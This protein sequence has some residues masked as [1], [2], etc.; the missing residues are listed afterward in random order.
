M[1]EIFIIPDFIKEYIAKCTQESD[2]RLNG[3]RLA[4]YI[5]PEIQ[6]WQ[7]NNE[8][9]PFKVVKQMLISGNYKHPKCETCGKIFPID[10]YGKRFCN[11]SCEMKCKEINEYVSK[12]S[13]SEKAKEKRKQTN[14][15]KYGVEN[16][17]ALKENREGAMLKKYGVTHALKMESSKNKAKKTNLERYGCENPH[18]NKDIIE[19]AE[20]TNIEKYGCKNVFQNEEIK[21]KIKEKNIEKYGA[22][23]FTQT[24]EYKEKCKITFNERYGVDNPN[25]IAEIKEKGTKTLIKKNRMKKYE[26]IKKIL[27]LKNIL[28]DM[29]KTEYINSDTIKYR[30]LNCNLEFHSEYTDPYKINCS[31]CFIRYG[32]SISE[33]EILD[34]VKT[35]YNN[36]IEE[37][38]RKIISPFELDIYIPEK[39]LAIEFNG[40]YWHSE[41]II[42]DKKYHQTKTLKCKEQGIRLIHIFE[43]EWHNK[44]DICKSLIKSSLGIYDRKIFARQCVVKNLNANQYNDFLVLNHLQGSVNSSIRLGLFYNDE[45]VAVIGFGKSRFKKD[46]IELHRFCCKLNYSIPGAFSKLIKHSNIDNFITYID[47]AHFTGNGYKSLG[48]KE[49]E[50]TEPNYKWVKGYDV[51]N[52]FAT[53]KYKLKDLL[54]ENYDEKMTES[55]N[56][57]MNGYT[58]IYDSGNMK[59]GYG[60]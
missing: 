6:E 2:G 17:F 45:L 58:K 56:M 40:D 22:E 54:K 52:R 13:Q 23:Y 9:I 4:L 28:I 38:N 48:F 60:M 25:Q 59:V 57:E 44:Q 49:I 26:I 1:T 39:K 46:E 55:E 21:Q 47:L 20:Q 27:L 7:N 16:V 24:D 12:C 50:I 34:Y 31:N 14:L 11:A 30:C 35:I 29:N 42:S 15:E 33:K 19:K 41:K 10:K 32:R 18:Q 43:Y 36:N 51:L 53:Q 8:N 3:K 37:N 5:T